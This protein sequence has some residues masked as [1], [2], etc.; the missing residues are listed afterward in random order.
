MRE[1]EQ[2]EDGLATAAGQQSSVLF[3]WDRFGPYHVDRCEAV[4]RLLSGRFDVTG[5]EIASF[6]DIYCWKKS[7]DGH[8]FT[9]ITLFPNVRRLSVNQLRCWL[10]LTAACLRLRARYVFACNYED[11]VI[12][13]A[14]LV[15]RMAGAKLIVMQDSK[16]D[17]KPRRLGWEILKRLFYAPYHA[18]LVASTRSAEY[19]AFLGFGRD[20]IFIGYDTVSVERIRKLAQTPPAPAGVPHAER[21]FTVIARFV[22]K[23]NLRLALDA[24]A[25]FVAQNPGTTRELHLC[26]A[27]ELE[28]DLKEHAAR[29]GLSGIK[30]RGFLQEAAI[31]STLGSTLALI[32]PS[33]EEQF[34][35][36]VN[37]AV[38]MGVPVLLSDN[39]GA[40]DMLVRTAVNGYIFEPDNPEG[41]AHFMSVLANDAAEWERLCRGNGRFVQVSDTE[42]F[43]QA[44]ERVI[45]VVSAGRRRK[46]EEGQA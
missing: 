13:F 32:L 6:D 15:L 42:Y 30:F 26:G 24:Y 29:L 27:G 23:K 11:P 40:R 33:I 1:I 39:C 43:A 9:K 2:Q 19:L 21:H 31:A 14:S 38:A 45:S 5:V 28:Q 25:Q 22:P 8:H 16:F 44:V 46:I 12:F 41:L 36:V 17:D 35:L 3:I 34:G 20:R 18:A 10:R 4:G 7:A 37:E